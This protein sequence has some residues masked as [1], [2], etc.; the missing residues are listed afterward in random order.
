MYIMYEISSQLYL[1]KQTTCY[2]R[3]LT[4]NARPDGP[5]Q[6]LVTKLQNEK[7]S[8]YQSNN[9]DRC[10]KPCLYALRNQQSGKLYCMNEV[11]ELVQFLVTNGYTIDYNLSK[12]LLKNT[13]VNG[14][15]NLIFYITYTP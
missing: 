10:Y 4:I 13:R 9:C 1:D 8:S 14:K 12:L 3:I 11:P 15:Q 2:E 7:L 5:L 6:A